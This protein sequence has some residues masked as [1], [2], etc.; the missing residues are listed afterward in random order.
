MASQVF[1]RNLDIHSGGIDL[2]FPHHENE[3]AQS[4]AYHD[5]LQ[6]GNYWIHAGHLHIQGRKMSKSLKNFVTVREYLTSGGN[7]DEFRMFCAM[8]GYDSTVEFSP[9]R[10][11]LASSL[12]NHIQRFIHRVRTE[13]TNS[14]SLRRRPDSESTMLKDVQAQAH[15]QIQQ[16]LANNFDTPRAMQIL[17]SLTQRASNSTSPST[18]SKDAIWNIAEFVND[19]LTGLGFGQF[20]T[21]QM[22][23]NP[24]AEPAARFRS[25]VRNLCRDRTSDARDLRASILS[26][27]DRFRSDAAEAGT[28][29]QDLPSG[30]FRCYQSGEVRSGE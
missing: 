24:L 10:L 16:A 23:L 18:G 9:E 11:K 1:G 17:H 3:I 5:S 6:W 7:A 21:G 2:C 25:R 27:C 20:S 13:R 15:A 30:D 4:E 19:C 8:F 14:A 12:L 28:V 22:G 26:E 29:I